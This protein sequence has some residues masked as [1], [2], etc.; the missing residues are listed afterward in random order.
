MNF[1]KALTDIMNYNNPEGI[2]IVHFGYWR[3]TMVAVEGPAVQEVQLAF[4][5]DWFFVSGQVPELEWRPENA[6]EGDRSV[7]V[8]A[9]GPADDLPRCSMM[10]TEA[11]HAAESR[12][13]ITSPYF[14]PDN[15]ISRALQL[16][17][18]RGVDVRILLPCKP[19]HRVVHWASFT[20]LDELERT[21]VRFFRY[22]KGLLHEKVVLV[23]DS[24]VLVGSVN[25]DNRSFYL[26]FE[27]TL[28]V[29][30]RGFAGE[31][32]RMLRADF[33]NSRPADGDAFKERSVWFRLLARLSR[34]LSPVL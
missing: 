33:D 18:L 13:W 5:Q 25:T 3:D 12:L 15:E 6:K 4:V 1:R 30:D 27:L 10:F 14:V 22:T 16:A 26:N 8:F 28:L 11:I 24:L 31:V 17:A 7:Q 19:D 9:T 20:Y 21:G 2:P 34:L 32:E 23:D 29:A